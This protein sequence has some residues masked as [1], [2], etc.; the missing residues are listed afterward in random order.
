MYNLHMF[1]HI[2]R[3]SSFK[4]YILAH[5]VVEEIGAL[6]ALEP[7]GHKNMLEINAAIICDNDELNSSLS[8]L[9]CLLTDSEDS[10]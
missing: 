5:T 1:C 3:N 9:D 2:W 6:E 4:C 10:Y 7:K 8:W